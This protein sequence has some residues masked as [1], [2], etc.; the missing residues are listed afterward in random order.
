MESAFTWLT[1]KALEKLCINSSF[2]PSFLLEATDDASEFCIF[3]DLFCTYVRKVHI[4]CMFLNKPYSHSL[5]TSRNKFMF[6]CSGVWGGNVTQ[7]CALW[8]IH[9]RTWML[10]RSR[11]SLEK[12]RGLMAGY[13]FKSY[14]GDR[15]EK[16]SWWVEFQTAAVRWVRPKLH[17]RKTWGLERESQTPDCLLLL[18]ECSPWEGCNW[19]WE[20]GDVEHNGGASPVTYSPHSK[21]SEWN[22]LIVATTTYTSLMDQDLWVFTS[23]QCMNLLWKSTT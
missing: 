10:G 9:W 8:R 14:E 11:K 4:S 12:G 23:Y 20:C 2:H 15:K 18:T 16:A 22:I 17:I 1:R 21:V 19:G 13:G 5:N 7:W 3:S 6:I